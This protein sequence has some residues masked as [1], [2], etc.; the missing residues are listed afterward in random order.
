MSTWSTSCFSH[1]AQSLP[2]WLLLHRPWRAP[3]LGTRLQAVGSSLYVSYTVAGNIEH[4]IV[5]KTT[6]S[7]ITVRHGCVWLL[8]GSVCLCLVTWFDNGV[9]ESSCAVKRFVRV[10]YGLCSAVAVDCKHVV[11]DCM[12]EHDGDISLSDKWTITTIESTKRFYTARKL[13]LP[14]LHRRVRKTKCPD[15]TRGNS[16]IMCMLERRKKNNS[17]V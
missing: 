4:G 17:I 10:W 5:Y 13:S 11:D 12:H 1:V 9:G 8:Y 3:W 16:R 6:A 15:D 14:G 7:R 2:V